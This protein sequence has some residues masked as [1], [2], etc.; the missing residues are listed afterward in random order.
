MWT[1]FTAGGQSGGTYVAVVPPVI[2][3]SPTVSRFPPLILFTNQ[4][5]LASI[6]FV[7]RKIISSRVIEEEKPRYDKV[8]STFPDVVTIASGPFGV[9]SQLAV[10]AQ[11]KGK[12]SDARGRLPAS[13]RAV[14]DAYGDGAVEARP[15]VSV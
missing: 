10:T 6:A 7:G 5:A 2:T 13:A 1:G 11:T 15:T 4:V 8:K 12:G 9:I 3:T 14:A